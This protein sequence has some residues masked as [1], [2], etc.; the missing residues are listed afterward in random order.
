MSSESEHRREDIELIRMLSREIP[1]VDL[2]DI[3][4]EA[5]LQHLFFSNR[6]EL[7]EF[8][9]KLVNSPILAQ[10]FIALG[11]QAQTLQSKPFNDVTIDDNQHL[12]AFVSGA[13]EHATVQASTA[14]KL[15]REGW[16]SPESSAVEIQS[17]KDSAIQLIGHSLRA[18]MESDMYVSSF[19]GAATLSRETD[20]EVYD[21]Y[22]EID[23][24]GRLHF[25][26]TVET[27]QGLPSGEM[28]GLYL[29]DPCGGALLLGQERHT[30]QS[31]NIEVD[32]FRQSLGV[33][34]NILSPKL[35]AVSEIS[36][37]PTSPRWRAY[38]HAREDGGEL[39][40]VPTSE[41]V[42]ASGPEV[43]EGQLFIEADLP[44]GFTEL[45]ADKSLSLHVRLGWRSQSLSSWNVAELSE[46]RHTFR[47]AY[48]YVDD[49]VVPFGS[50]FFFE[51]H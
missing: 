49:F 47:V 11:E 5:L 10:R 12:V 23:A 22:A 18:S 1:D 24:E 28:L 33:D 6:A 40:R 7:S 14:K 43:I 51:I 16:I 29:L 20:L 4:D 34:D 9:K 41:L 26:A 2:Q 17:V 48:P 25:Q 38:I 27:S 37:E 44:D 46:G 50:M 15:S 13:I 42:L 35:F 45:Y 32:R 31:W 36:Q 3:Q 39:S 8:A 19:R 30:D 21:A